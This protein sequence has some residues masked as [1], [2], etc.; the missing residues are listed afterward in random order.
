MV[1]VVAP[2]SVEPEPGLVEGEMTGVDAAD[3]GEPGTTAVGAAGVGGVVG[4]AGDGFE[5]TGAVARLED[6][7]GP[8]AGPGAASEVVVESEP[9]GAKE[10]EGSGRELPGARG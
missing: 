5:T 6:V 2:G 8:T 10:A 1:D 4:V 9:A 3:D 7:L